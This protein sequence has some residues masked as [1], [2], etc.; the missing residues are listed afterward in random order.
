MRDLGFVVSRHQ[1]G[2]KMR[3]GVIIE[4]ARAWQF[5][6]SNFLLGNKNHACPWVWFKGFR[7]TRLVCRWYQAKML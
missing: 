4:G 3:V 5:L 1:K 2:R 7:V 6:I